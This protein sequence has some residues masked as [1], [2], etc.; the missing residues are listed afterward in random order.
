MSRY[1]WPLAASEGDELD[2]ESSLWDE[3]RANGTLT[4]AGQPA[5]YGVMRPVS[6]PRCPRITSKVRRSVDGAARYQ[7]KTR[8]AN[9]RRGRKG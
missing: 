6:D 1:V 4:P 8:P 5:G 9:K 7:T 3:C 2:W